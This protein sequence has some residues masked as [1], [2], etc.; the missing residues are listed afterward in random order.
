MDLAASMP[1]NKDPLQIPEFPDLTFEIP[2]WENGCQAVA[3]LDEAGRGAWAGPVSAGAVILPADAEILTRLA[4]V[5]DSKQLSPAER[6]RL[7][8]VIKSG[9]ASWGVGMSSAE[10]IDRLGIVP[11]TRLAMR[12]A[13]ENLDPKPQYLLLDYIRIPEIKLPQLSLVKGDARCLS[14]AAASILAKTARD[15]W[16]VTLDR[17]FPQYGF[18]LHKGYGT[19][20]H[21]RALAEFG[22]CPYHRQSF[23]PIRVTETQVSLP[24]F[25]SN[26]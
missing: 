13:M 24:D 22:P 8:D 6:T 17:D 16:M 23:K 10:E 11:A 12:R 7:A 21:R 9:S 18:R 2:L 19:M 15:A 4:G 14:I 25:Q 26:L 20:L 1:R 5:D 3:G